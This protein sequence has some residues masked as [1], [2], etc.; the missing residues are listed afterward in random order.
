[1]L[2]ALGLTAMALQSVRHIPLYAIVIVPLLAAR[3][4]AEVPSLRRPLAA[5]RRPVLLAVTWPL[6]G[7]SVLQMIASAGDVGRMQ[8]GREPLGASYPSGAVEY[9]R[10]HNPE[11]RLFNTYHWGGYL[12]YQLHPDRTVFIDGRADVYGDRFIERYMEVA[13][14]QPRWRQVL[15]EYDVGLVLVEKESPLAVVLGDDAGWQE[16]YAGDVERLFARRA[17]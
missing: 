8:F 12:V 16:L 14:L 15:D 3:L 6:L 4:Q 7:L 5:W 9:L 17:R 13:R 1:V 11:G 2:W 10:A